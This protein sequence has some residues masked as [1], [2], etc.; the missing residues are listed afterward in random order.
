MSSASAALKKRLT[1]RM[2]TPPLNTGSRTVA[3]GG[4]AM[5]SV[6]S[7]GMASRER[8]RRSAER[9]SRPCVLGISATAMC[10]RQMAV[11]RSATSANTCARR[12][13]GRGRQR[14]RARACARTGAAAPARGAYLH[15]AAE[16]PEVER[17]ARAERGEALGGAPEVRD[18]ALG[19]VLRHLRA[20]EELLRALDREREVAR[21]V[22]VVARDEVLA[23]RGLRAVQRLG[24]RVG[25]GHRGDRRRRGG[26]RLRVELVQLVLV[27]GDEHRV[28]GVQRRRRG[29]RRVREGGRRRAAEVQGPERA[30]RRQVLGDAVPC[31]V[32]RGRRGR[33]VHLHR[34]PCLPACLPASPSAPMTGISPLVRSYAY[35]V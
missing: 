15:E 7:V 4:S 2:S 25:R 17:D 31:G 13:R 24:A 9:S 3:G 35:A 32:G 11:A 14:V 22:A 8:P 16:L 1:V 20:R 29:V 28:R 23:V 30:R 6:A 34:R 21:L 33:E 27:V 26:R 18:A 19:V 12:G 10:T 5:S